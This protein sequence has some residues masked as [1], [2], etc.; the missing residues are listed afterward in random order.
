MSDGLSPVVFAADGFRGV[1][2]LNQVTSGSK[3][4][5]MPMTFWGNLLVM[6]DA[7]S[8]ATAAKRTPNVYINTRSELKDAQFADAHLNRLWAFQQ[9]S[10]GPQAIER[11]HGDV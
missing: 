10:I 8:Q 6:P 9:K 7:T 11:P 3:V 5:D 1:P 4:V 2:N